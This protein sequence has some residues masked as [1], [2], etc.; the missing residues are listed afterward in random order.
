MKKQNIFY[1]ILFFII[2]ILINP[3]S[4]FSQATSAGFVNVPQGGSD[5]LGWTSGTNRNLVIKNEDNYSLRFF[6]NAGSGG[7]SNLRMIVDAGNS[8]LSGFIGIGTNFTAPASRLHVREN[9]DNNAWFQ[10]TG[11]NTGDASTD[12]FRVGVTNS[13]T[14]TAQSVE[15][16]QQENADMNFFTNGNNQRA[17]IKA[18]GKVGIN[19][20]SPSNL[21]HVHD[22]LAQISNSTTGSTSSD[23]FSI[24]QNSSAVELKQL[25]NS[26]MNFFTN[27]SNQRA[28]IKADGKVGINLTS[29]SNLFHV[30]DGLSQISNSTTGSTSNDGFTIGQNNSDVQLKQLENAHMTFFTHDGTSVAERMRLSSAGNLSVGT[31]SAGSSRF[32]AEVSNSVGSSYDN[33]MLGTN[34]DPTG[35]GEKCAIR[36]E[37]A[38]SRSGGYYNIGG[39]FLS[40][41]NSGTNSVNVGV[42]GG[43]TG[44]STTQYVNAG[45]FWVT[46]GSGI[47][48]KGV[49]GEASTSGGT[50]NFGVYGKAQNGSTLN[51]GIY[52]VGGSSCVNNSCANAAGF[53]SGDVAVSGK[54]YQTSDAFLKDNI[55]PLSNA[56][57]ILN[58]LHPKTYIFKTR[59][60]PSMHLSEGNQFGLVVE[61]VE[62]ILPELV[63]SF[64]QPE[65]RDDRG[66]VLYQQIDFK[67]LDYNA[68]TP[69]LI[70]A[71][72]EQG[73]RIDAQEQHIAALEETIASCCAQPRT[74]GDAG[75]NKSGVELK[76]DEAILYKN[77][78]NPF[79]N[80]T[81]I[82]YFI[83]ANAGEAKILFQDETGRTIK[84]I[85][86]VEKGLSELTVNTTD[87]NSGIYTYSLWLSGKVIDTKKMVKTK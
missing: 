24:G 39:H 35:M 15:I 42:M 12:G 11:N 45:H 58:M 9:S 26:D 86:I 16:R 23:G 65:I 46:D 37:C 1:S 53:F 22:G 85:P 83:P 72:Q 73:Q 69:I 6:T 84:E 20:T 33:A 43:A 68:F 14:A 62:P 29:P 4:L 2:A 21:F 34:A 49:Y 3:N 48:N 40:S 87:L 5:Y 79:N 64:K 32:V 31:A 52:G 50:N 56:T 30:H 47:D 8:A 28:T 10:I 17:T 55:Q 27:G 67:S 70:A 78:P 7:T 82:G 54:L 74:T 18:D 61:D 19:L 36:G 71:F 51:Y 57:G 76:S 25:E 77:H 63:K 60:Y 44:E 41:G 75:T 80:S 38:S 81:V 13:A 59:D 66:N